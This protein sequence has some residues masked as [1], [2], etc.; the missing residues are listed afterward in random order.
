MDGNAQAEPCTRKLAWFRSATCM[1][2]LTQVHGW[3]FRSAWFRFRRCMDGLENRNRRDKMS[4]LIGRLALRLNRRL[5]LL[6]QHHPALTNASEQGL[7]LPDLERTEWY[8]IKPL[9]KAKRVAARIENYPRKF[10]LGN[11]WRKPLEMPKVF[12]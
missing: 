4:R 6:F 2:G 5:Q 10:R 11:V 1:V 7:S 8:G 9:P 3:T 12:Q